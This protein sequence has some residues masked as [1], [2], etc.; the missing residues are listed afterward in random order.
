MLAALCRMG[1]AKHWSVNSRTTLPT[2][3]EMSGCCRWQSLNSTLATKSFLC[4]TGT[5]T[6]ITAYRMNLGTDRN[7]TSLDTITVAGIAR[8]SYSRPGG[9]SLDPFIQEAGDLVD[10]SFA[11]G[12]RFSEIS[13]MNPR[14]SA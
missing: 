6:L 13:E 9:V 3:M 12:K 7:L 14:A 8:A 5:S 11:R 10:G 4:Q 1:T 2:N